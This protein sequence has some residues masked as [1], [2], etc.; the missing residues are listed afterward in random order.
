MK[1]RPAVMN[2]VWFFL[3]LVSIMVAAYTGKMREVVDASFESAKGAVTLAIGLVG[4]MALWLGL[5][6]IAEKGG[7]MLL[8]ARAIRPA[9]VHLFPRIPPE[10]PA[11]SAMVMNISANALGLGNAATPMGL[12]AMMELDRLNP[13]KGR[14]TDAMCMFL[15]INTSNVTLLPLGVIAVRA[16]AGSAEPASILVPTLLATL[17][18]TAV[19]ILA[20]RFL[21]KTSK[22]PDPDS[23]YVESGVSDAAGPSSSPPAEAN[24]SAHSSDEE[25]AEHSRP[26]P[27]GRWMC[28][29]FVAAFLAGLLLRFVQADS[30]L[31]AGKEVISF[32]LLPAIMGALVV[33]GYLRGVGVYEAATEGAKEGFQVAVRIIP[34]LVMILV[35][36]AMFRASGAFDIMVRIL[37]PGISLIGMPAEAL[38]MALMRP[39]SGSGAFGIMSEV[40]SQAPDSF[41]AF[42]VSTMQGST[43]TTF[44]VLAV[45]FGSVSITRT[46]HALSAALLADAAGILGALAFCHLFY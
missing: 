5:M 41:S 20:A 9:M 45:Y 25:A 26:G 34:F 42:L 40:V 35:A 21:A 44:Y 13:V 11:M 12:K 19:A 38:P 1:K 17:C 16:S 22:D 4:A 28:W 30:M 24:S 15:A 31:E 37:T 29:G 3:V 43:E 23:L 46:R 39:L 7:L 14:A 32:W 10:H 8:V 36:I 18:S 6:K 27:V 33:F 2:G